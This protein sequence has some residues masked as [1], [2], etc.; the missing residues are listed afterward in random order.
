[1]PHVN[2]RSEVHHTRVVASANSRLQSPEEVK[3]RNGKE[4]QDWD[5][6]SAE[7]S[8]DPISSKDIEKSLSNTKLL[9]HTSFIKVAPKINK[10]KIKSLNTLRITKIQQL[11]A[12]EF[13]SQSIKMFDMHILNMKR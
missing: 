10:K 5:A 7:S 4:D 13:C 11:M 2:C 9:P 3:M 1:M 8:F 12:E 6:V